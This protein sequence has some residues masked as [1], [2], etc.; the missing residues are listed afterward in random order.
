MIHILKKSHDEL[1][2]KR[3]ILDTFHTNIEY[4]MSGSQDGKE[5]IIL[6]LL[7]LDIS[8]IYNISYEELLNQIVNYERTDE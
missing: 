5:M 7:L 4:Q 8:R 6:K 3:K 2:L 1:K